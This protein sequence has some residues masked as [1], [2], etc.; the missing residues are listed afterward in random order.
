MELYWYAFFFIGNAVHIVKKDD[1]EV[2]WVSFSTILKIWAVMKQYVI[3]AVPSLRVPFKKAK[4]NEYEFRS[5]CF[6]RLCHDRTKSFEDV[7]N[8][9]GWNLLRNLFQYQENGTVMISDGAGAGGGGGSASLS[10]GP[11]V[12]PTI[13]KWKGKKGG[14]KG[15]GGG[16]AK[17][18]G[19]GGK[20]SGQS[21]W[22]QWKA[23]KKG[24]VQC[25]GKPFWESYQ[26]VK[27]CVAYNQNRPCPVP[28]CN[29]WHW[30][31]HI[32]C[33]KGKSC[34]AINHHVQY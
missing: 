25:Q 24:H 16:A 14:G 7:M 34:K 1:I 26:G 28:N 10:P 17:G 15:G 31:S 6:Q 19:D 20:G 18:K 13:K 9:S 12:Q 11:G 22:Q 8:E 23:Q 4:Q 33:N 32:E 2:P 21:K 29:Q 27:F 3:E 30:C 5:E